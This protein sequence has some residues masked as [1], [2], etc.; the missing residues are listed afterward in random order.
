MFFAK[1]G[2]QFGDK[3]SLEQQIH[4]ITTI[5]E[6]SLQGEPLHRFSVDERLTWM[7]VRDTALTEDKAYSL[8]GIFDVRIATVYGE[9]FA[10]AHGRLFEQ[11]KKRSECV[12]DPRLSNPCDDKKRIEHTK[13]GLLVDAYI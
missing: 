8:A 5:L 6:A 7:T 12:R 4:G 10:Q 3:R 2:R 1:D 11:I 9:G 13:S